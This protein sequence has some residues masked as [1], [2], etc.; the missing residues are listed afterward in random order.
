MGEARNDVVH[1]QMKNQSLA[2]VLAASRQAFEKLL[3]GVEAQPEAFLIESQHFEGAPG[4]MLVWEML[5]GDVYEHY[6]LHVPS[7]KNWLAAGRGK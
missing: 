3:A 2:D 1:Q 5:R 4:P 6:A 7:I